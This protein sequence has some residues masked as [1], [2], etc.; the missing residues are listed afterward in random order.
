MTPRAE[1]PNRPD[2]GT[3]NAEAS[4]HRL[5][6]RSSEGRFPFATRSGR[7]PTVL[8]FEGSAPAKAGVNHSPV[9][10]TTVPLNCQPP[11][12]WPARPLRFNSGLPG[13][14]GSSQ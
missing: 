5:I 6:D 11:A 9:D 3:L 12:T 2:G 7:P 14:R 8:V 4:N 10:V 1:F 13:P